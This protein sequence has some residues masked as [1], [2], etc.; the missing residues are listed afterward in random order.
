MMYICTAEVWRLP[1]LADTAVANASAR[2]A[3]MTVSRYRP[4]PES[5]RVAVA[6]PRPA[7]QGKSAS[8]RLLNWKG[9]TLQGVKPFQA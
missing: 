8:L 2:R 6:K 1:W 4:L 7:T 5:S 3:E 9:F